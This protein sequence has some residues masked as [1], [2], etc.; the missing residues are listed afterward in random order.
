[1]NQDKA[2]LGSGWSFPPAFDKAAK[3]VRLTHDQED[4][5]RSLEILLGTLKGERVMR[6]AY[7]ANVDEMVFESF[8]QSIKTY[9][10]DQISTAIYYFEPRIE[11]L[12][13]TINDQFITDG[14]L[15]IE[16]DYVIRATNSRY[17]IVYPFFLN[18][19][20]GVQPGS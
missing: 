17:N 9:M 2:F 14:Q 16:I 20:A 19:G 10:A 13:V 8:N 5:E 12:N 6:P 4:I 1:M 18:E 3:K 7:G 15:L 11:P